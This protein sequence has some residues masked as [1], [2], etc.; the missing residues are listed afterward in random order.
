[1]INRKLAR[2][3]LCGMLAVGCASVTGGA[4][5]GSVIGDVTID[6]IKT[7]PTA[8]TGTFSIGSDSSSNVSMKIRVV[9]L[10]AVTAIIT[11]VFWEMK[12]N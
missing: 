4:F 10:V 3:V 12:S 7:T 1:M 8:S 6:N 9:Q 2:K 5:A 11:E